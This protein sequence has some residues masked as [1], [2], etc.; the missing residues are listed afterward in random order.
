MNRGSIIFLVLSLVTIVA[1]TSIF[2]EASSFQKKTKVTDGTVVS[3]DL[4]YFYIKYISDDG[5]EHTHRGTQGKNKKF[6]VG[7][8]FRVF[9]LKDNPYKSRISD[10]KKGGRKVIITGIALLFLSLTSIYQNRSRNKSANKFRTTGRKV[11]AEITGIETDMN[12]TVLEKHPYIINCRWVDPITGKEYLDA[13]KQIWKDP[14]PLLG[15]R[16]HI[17]VY[18]DRDNPD[19]YFIDIEFLGDIK[20]Y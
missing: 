20:A 7:D 11:E 5:A 12:T 15:G 9:Y 13:I 14:A 16:N 8:K 1:G 19:K 17:D 10:G 4:T 6:Y 2:L 18:I 3:R